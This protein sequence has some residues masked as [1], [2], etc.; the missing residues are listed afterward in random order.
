MCIAVF[1]APR[2]QADTVILFDNSFNPTDDAQA[3]DR[4]HRLGQLRPVSVYRLVVERT[5][6]E[7]IVA[8]ASTK[9]ELDRAIRGGPGAVAAGGG[10]AVAASASSASASSPTKK[11]GRPAGG[12]SSA[13]AASS[14]S[15]R[16][17]G[18]DPEGADSVSLLLQQALQYM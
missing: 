14:A 2:P 10:A 17:D 16:G 3:V 18:D 5:I 7:V 12:K 11:M 9:Q 8:V 4:V 6:E 15:Q 13:G 1:P